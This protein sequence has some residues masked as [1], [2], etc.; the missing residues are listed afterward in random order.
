ML[1]VDQ[2]ILSADVIHINVVGISPANR[3][4]IIKSEIVT[5]VIKARITLID[6][7][8]AHVKMVRTAEIRLETRFFDMPAA[9]AAEVM[10]LF[11]ALCAL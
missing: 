2:V 9:V 1:R 6:L 4:R 3:P 5:T 8:L 11:G 7:R 10:V